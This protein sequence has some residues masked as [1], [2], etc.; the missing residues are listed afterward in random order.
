[1]EN[2]MAEEKRVNPQVDG[3][4][5][6]ALGEIGTLGSVLGGPVN[7]DVTEIEV[8]PLVETRNEKGER[9]IEVRV[10]RPLEEM[11]VVGGGKRSL[12]TF[13]EERRYS[14]PVSV[15]R[16]LEAIGALYH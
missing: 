13:E 15:A 3:R 11:S 1:M 7:V 12:Y 9:M 14:V 2:Q 5:E 6:E 4:D 10:N 8:D 16:E